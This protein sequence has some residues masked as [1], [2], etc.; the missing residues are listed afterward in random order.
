M[1]SLKKSNVEIALISFAINLFNFF[2]KGL[3]S[4]K[5]LILLK[6][7]TEMWFIIKNFVF[8]GRLV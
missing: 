7:I 6:W 2:K 1:W 3:G 8:D 4:F 5:N